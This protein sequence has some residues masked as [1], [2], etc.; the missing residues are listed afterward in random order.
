MLL[1]GRASSRSLSFA[2]REHFDADIAILD[3]D[4][5][6]EVTQDSLLSDACYS[7]YEGWT[8]RG[9][10]TDTLVR[11]RAVF[12]DGVIVEGSDGHGRYQRRSLSA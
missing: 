10:V 11:G 3:L 4:A 12:R 8:M 5:E 2:D 9:K 6:Y 1:C 7:I